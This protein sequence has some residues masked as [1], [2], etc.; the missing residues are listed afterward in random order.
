MI[1]SATESGQ[2]AESTSHDIDV[3]AIGHALVDILCEIAEERLPELGLGD[4]KGAMHLV[5]AARSEWLYEAVGPTSEASGGSASNTAAGVKN[6]GGS[7]AFIGTVADDQF[8]AIF[9]HDLR[10][11]G[12]IYETAALTGASTGRS[13][14]LVT[15][16]GERTMN[17]FIG[18]GSQVGESELLSALLDR[19]TIVYVEGYL[20]DD[21]HPVDVWRK[22]VERVHAGGGKFSITLSDLFCVDRHRDLFLSLLDGSIDICFGN[23]E[24]VQALFPNVSLDEAVDALAQRCEV[25]VITR[26]A[27]GSTLVR[28][29]E[30][31]DVPAQEVHVVDTT[32]AGDQFAAGVLTALALGESLEVAG[33]LGAAAAAAV[34]SRLGARLP[35]D[36]VLDGSATAS[37]D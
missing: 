7:S 21:A 28:D 19:A 32:G 1:S 26:G 31:V 18:A 25:A 11:V 20:F 9:A 14:I 13:L 22:V 12:V 2:A 10:S 16:D 23:E 27:R 36:L 8:G 4:G 33:T 35:R 34:I 15:P 5:D 3:L 30:K 6:C 29:G 37:V 17:T 24:E